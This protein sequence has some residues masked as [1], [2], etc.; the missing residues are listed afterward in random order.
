M[1]LLIVLYYDCIT[2]TTNSIVLLLIGFW[3]DIGQPKDFITGTSLYL[4]HIK[5]V[6]PD[7]LAKG[8]NFKSPVLVVG[9]VNFNSINNLHCKTVFVFISHATIQS[10]K[11]CYSKPLDCGHLGHK[12]RHRL[13]QWPIFNIEN[14]P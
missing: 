4:G 5:Q 8:D 9:W 1:L 14:L 6:Q 10:V 3:M 12:L 11:P 2:S 7:C 13:I